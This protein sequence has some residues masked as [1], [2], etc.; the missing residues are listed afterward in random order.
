MLDGKDTDCELTVGV[1]PVAAPVT[2][3]QGRA[4]A[5]HLEDQAE[6]AGLAKIIDQAVALGVD[7]R[8]DVVRDLAGPVAEADAP[9]K[10]RGPDP[11]GHTGPA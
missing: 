1:I 5:G 7:I 3:E 2:A 9:V 8:F 11:Q 4:K 10:R 6:R